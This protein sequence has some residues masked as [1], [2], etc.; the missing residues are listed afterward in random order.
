MG[1]IVLILEKGGVAVTEWWRW[2]DVIRVCEG[3]GWDEVCGVQGV[4]KVKLVTLES[5]LSLH[6]LSIQAFGYFE[7]SPSQVETDAKTQDRS[8]ISR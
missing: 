5:D 4:W 6:M 1:I 3:L 2:I 7:T 8:A